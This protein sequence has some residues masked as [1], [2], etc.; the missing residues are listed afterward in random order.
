LHSSPWIARRS[1]RC[2]VCGCSIEGCGVG[3]RPPA[4]R[5][6]HS[7]H[8]DGSARCE[9]LRPTRT[10]RASLFQPKRASMSPTGSA[11][12]SGGASRMGRGVSGTGG[13]TPASKWSSVHTYARSPRIGATRE[14]TGAST[15]PIVLLGPPSRPSERERRPS[16]GHARGRIDWTMR[17]L[18]ERYPRPDAQLAPSSAGPRDARHA[19]HKLTPRS[20]ARITVR[21]GHQPRQSQ[22]RRHR[23]P[24]QPRRRLRYNARDATQVL[25]LLGI[26][27]P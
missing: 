11:T 19:G 4:S 7:Q 9:L 14:T 16:E 24:P 6:H 27:S 25:P 5:G 12:R 3:S 2:S 10:A 20:P 26:T 13:R 1:R 18:R 23:R 21:R 8:P 17:E 22:G 15:A